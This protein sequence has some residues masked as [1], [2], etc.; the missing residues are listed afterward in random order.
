MFVLGVLALLTSVRAYDLV[1]DY[2]G[3]SFFDRWDFY[4]YWDNLV[5]SDVWWLNRNDAFS[6]G[7]TYINNAGNAVLKVDNE[8]DV[9]WNY[10]RNSVRITSQDTYAV[11]SLWITD[12]VHVPYGTH[13]YI[14]WGAIWTKGPTWPDNGEIDIFE[15]INRMPINQYALHTTE[16]CM[17]DTPDNQVGTTVVEDC[18][19]AA[20]CTVTENYE[21]SAYTGFAE[22]GGGVWATQFDVSGIWF[23]SRPHVP[24]SIT[25]STSTSGV[26]LS[27]WGPPS[28]AF[29]STTCN[30]TEYFTPQN[31]V[32]DIT[33]CGN[34]AG[35]P[36]TYAET[37]SGGTTGLCYND[38]VIGS[39]ANYNDAY[40]EIK[41]IRAYTTGGVAPTPTANYQGTIPTITGTSALQSS[42]S[43]VG[44]ALIPTPWYYPGAAAADTELDS[45]KTHLALM[46][47]YFA[48]YDWILTTVDD[49]CRTW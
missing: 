5:R 22:A 24:A 23:W 48:F 27:D 37:C 34:W 36:E 45:A 13:V 32:I 17:K 42:T 1:R 7:L 11:G 35:L 9:A 40:F 2:S 44:T 31:L 12:V 43:T 18:S 20:G 46:T 29:P 19:E 8:H 16:G 39:G 38:N 33:L 25:Q 41:N 28:A 15:T 26:D 3:S 21:N 10:K 14:V 49:P 4:G 30:I 47:T 6:Q